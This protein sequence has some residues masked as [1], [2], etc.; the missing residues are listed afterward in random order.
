[1]SGGSDA[2]SVVINLP[3]GWEAT[4]AVHAVYDCIGLT[5]GEKPDQ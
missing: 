2:D 1:M 5:S 4:A 3:D